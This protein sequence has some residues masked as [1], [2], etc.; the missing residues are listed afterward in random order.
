MPRCVT[1]KL[2]LHMKQ[3]PNAVQCLQACG[4]DHIHNPGKRIADLFL[5]AQQLQNSQDQARAGPVGTGPKPVEVP[6]PKRAYWLGA[7]KSVFVLDAGNI[8]VLLRP[9]VLSD[10]QR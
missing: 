5:K 3:S 9:G 7:T 2:R 1:Y 4:L 10:V 6:L 8:E